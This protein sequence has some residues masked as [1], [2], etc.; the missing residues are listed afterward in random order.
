V[1][2]ARGAFAEIQSAY[3]VWGA[4]AAVE[5]V[6]H[7]GGHVFEGTRFRERLTGT[8]G[9]KPASPPATVP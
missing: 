8:F 3:G 6:V 4:A 1:D 7:P 2:L 9:V 5:W